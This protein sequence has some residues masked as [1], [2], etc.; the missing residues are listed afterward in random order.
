MD[1]SNGKRAPR[2]SVSLPIPECWGDNKIVLMVRDP[3]M[4]YAYWEIQADVENRVIKEI[5]K[6]GLVVSKSVLKV[7][8]VM[9]GSAVEGSPVFSSFDLKNYANSWYIQIEN[10]GKKWAVDIGIE[11][12]TG[13]FFLLARSNIVKAPFYGVSGIYDE[14]WM[15]SEELYYKMF[16]ISGGYGIGTSSLEMR[17][18]MKRRPKSWFS[19]GMSSGMIEDTSSF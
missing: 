1:S 9:D 2:Q 8:D 18:T 12:T 14:E 16:A 17:E 7:R 5:E 6:K 19:S 4:L 3:W 15:C 13:E 11:S 10:S